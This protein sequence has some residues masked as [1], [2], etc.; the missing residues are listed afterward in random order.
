[1]IFGFNSMVDIELYL[2]FVFIAI[3]LE[4]TDV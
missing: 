1:M 2:V 3:V 4:N